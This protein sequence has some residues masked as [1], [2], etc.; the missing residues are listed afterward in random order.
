MLV[1]KDVAI[2]TGTAG[3][4]LALM[5]AAGAKLDFDPLSTGFGK[6]RINNTRIDMGAGE[7]QVARMAS[8]MIMGRKKTARGKVEEEKR[9]DIA[10]KFL[11]YKLSPTAGVAWDLLA[12]QTFLG[13][14]FTVKHLASAETI[15][16]RL[17]PL[18]LQDLDDAIEEEGMF[19]GILLGLPAGFG[20]GVQTYAGLWDRR[21][22][23]FKE[24]FPGKDFQTEH[25]KRGRALIRTLDANPAV[26][27]EL[28]ELESKENIHDQEYRTEAGRRYEEINMQRETKFRETI[29]AGRIQGKSLREL[30]K[31]FKSQ[32]F[33]LGSALFS[34][35]EGDIEADVFDSKADEIA[36]EY[37]DVELMEDPVTGNLDWKGR[38]EARTEILDKAIYHNVPLEYLMGKG[39]ASF[40][41]T[42]YMDPIVREVIFRYEDDSESLRPYW[43]VERE[44]LNANPVA[45][46]IRHQIQ[47]AQA[48]GEP[49]ETIKILKGMSTFKKFEKQRDDIRALLRETN[50]T[51]DAQ[52]YF[53]GFIDNLSSIHARMILDRLSLDYL[54]KQR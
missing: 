13:E 51:W 49:P 54:T 48:T 19:P 46:E 22:E 14:D 20:V 9:L 30:V 10:V 32:R 41:G 52:L 35:L 38:D 23:A 34:E 26:I 17:A 2:A 12:G 1:A 37:L 28:E 53:W 11:Q 4:A 42:K 39:P 40:R 33:A 47:V 45:N 36:L 7:L 18:F 24:M 5:Y 3:T 6:G 29:L 50:P 43:D 16:Q 15:R 25:N 31:D 8:Q 44:M 21:R 27:K